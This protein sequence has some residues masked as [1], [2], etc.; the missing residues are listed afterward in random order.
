MKF[1]VEKYIGSII[2]LVSILC[3]C[4]SSLN[5]KVNGDVFSNLKKS[6]ELDSTV[7]P[8]YI[9]ESKDYQIIST[10]TNGPEKH[11]TLIPEKNIEIIIFKSYLDS[12]I[13]DIG[14]YKDRNIKYKDIQIRLTV[15]QNNLI[16]IDT[17]FR[18]DQFS[19]Y[20][21][22]KVDADF[23]KKSFLQFYRF[24]EINDNLLVFYGVIDHNKYNSGFQ[25]S[26]FF[27]LKNKKLS[28]SLFQSGDAY[29]GPEGEEKESGLDSSLVIDT[30]N[31]KDSIK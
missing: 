11:I 20:V 3:S 30:L 25:F 6:V 18:R 2:V 21:I 12:Y 28:F 15:K 27:D 8:T 19:K 16:L 31:K 17:I 1:F 5:S 9:E 13:E 22:E 4:T 29:E 24:Y 23:M 7:K 26:H 10:Y 14:T